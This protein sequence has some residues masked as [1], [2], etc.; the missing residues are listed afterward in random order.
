M[1]Q[2]M[3][4]INTSDRNFNVTWGAAPAAAGQNQAYAASVLPKLIALTPTAN[5]LADSG[6]GRM[7]TVASLGVDAAP[8]LK[9]RVSISWQFSP[10]SATLC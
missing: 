7:V 2:A 10:I 4:Q 9:A 5:E 1:P 8:D 6:V 3:P